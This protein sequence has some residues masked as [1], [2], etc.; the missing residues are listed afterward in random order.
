MLHC[1]FANISTYLDLLHM[2][3]NVA[4]RRQY[5]CTPTK[6]G[7]AGLTSNIDIKRLAN[8]GT[9]SLDIAY[10]YYCGSVRNFYIF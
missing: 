10:F 8:V 5:A 1:I 9:P 4:V 7:P 3:T 2:A 6:H